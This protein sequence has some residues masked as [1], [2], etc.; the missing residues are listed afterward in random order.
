MVNTEVVVEKCIPIFKSAANLNTPVPRESNQYQEEN[1]YE[2]I[3][4]YNYL[5]E[6]SSTIASP[7]DEILNIPLNETFTIA[8]HNQSSS[9]LLEGSDSSTLRPVSAS[10]SI[11]TL[12][13]EQTTQEEVTVNEERDTVKT[14]DELDIQFFK[15]AVLKDTPFRASQTKNR[16]K[17]MK[18]LT[19]FKNKLAEHFLRG[20]KDDA[21]TSNV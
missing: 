12:L 5:F 19:D 7:T 6:P 3:C 14:P 8:C 13:Q 4:N 15:S 20:D 2:N 1:I 21:H 17:K 9:T 10:T 11:S 16:F 18:S